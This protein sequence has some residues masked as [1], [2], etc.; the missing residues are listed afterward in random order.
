MPARD[1]VASAAQILRQ[2]HPQGKIA[3]VAPKHPSRH[4]RHANDGEKPGGR[5]TSTGAEPNQEE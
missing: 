3:C 4:S 1:R 5:D 2:I